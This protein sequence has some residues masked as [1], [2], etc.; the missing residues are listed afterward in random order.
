MSFGCHNQKL[1]P[2]LRTE[3]ACARSCCSRGDKC[4][5]YVF[6]TDGQCIHSQYRRGQCG[7]GEY[8]LG[9]GARGYQKVPKQI[10]CPSPSWSDV[11]RMQDEENVMGGTSDC[12][13]LHP[14]CES[15][16]AQ[17]QCEANANFMRANCPM[18]CRVDGC[19]DKHVGCKFWADGN[20]CE[21]NFLFML[22][23]CPVACRERRERQVKEK[24]AELLA[25]HEHRREVIDHKQE[26]LKEKEEEFEEDEDE[27]EDKGTAGGKGAPELPQRNSEETDEPEEY[28]PAR[29]V[30]RDD[31]AERKQAA[32]ARS[33]AI[34][35]TPVPALDHEELE[36]VWWRVGLFAVACLAVLF[37]CSRRLRRRT[38][39]VHVGKG[40]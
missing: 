7:D 24:R 40:L 32:R 14:D 22:D 33:E 16:A 25:A 30:K 37:L 28:R 18:S 3:E 36:V 15:W 29:I 17:S 2:L 11:Q 23:K 34:R 19:W 12:R 35:A 9:D 21:T 4:S 27:D 26:E 13:D 39:K 31:R 1:R 6:G 5:H 38:S 8:K 20:Q 10:E